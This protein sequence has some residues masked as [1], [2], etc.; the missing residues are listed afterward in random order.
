MA[1][2]LVVNLTMTIELIDDSNGEHDASNAHCVLC[3]WSRA[4]K[5]AQSARRGLA[6]HLPHCP[7]KDDSVAKSNAII[8]QWFNEMTGKTPSP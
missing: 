2:K 5:S 8:E 4:Y 3:G 6:A 1:K 7:H